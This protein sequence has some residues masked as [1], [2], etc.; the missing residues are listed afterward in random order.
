MKKAQDMRLVSFTRSAF[1]FFSHLSLGLV[2]LMIHGLAQAQVTYPSKSIRILVP[3][4]PGG[5]SDASARL[6]AEHLTQLLG[7]QV[8]VENK[9][10][11]SGNISGQF[12]AQAAPDGYTIMLAYNGQMTINPFIFANMPFDTV[13]DLA[14]IGKIGDY[15]SVLTINPAVDAKTIKEL[16]QLSKNSPAGLMYGTSGPGSVE[17][18]ITSLFIQ[19]TGAQLTHV[20]YKGA[21]VALADAVAGHIP[22]AMTSV[23]GGAPLIKAGKLRALAV[24]SAQRSSAL[25]DVP[26]FIESGLESFVMNSWIGLVAPGQTPV[27]VIQRLNK[28]LNSALAL[29]SLQERLNELGINVVPGSPEDFRQEIQSDLRINGPIIKAAAIR[30]N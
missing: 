17:H 26:T 24:S 28:A 21:G 10:G 22:L 15:P 14:P 13:R 8:V 11:A 23:A 7:Q 25:S 9:P 20:P 2:C 3:F 18:V 5:V 27:P 19:R 12:L 30:V 16:I 6:V 1:S 29:K 4:T